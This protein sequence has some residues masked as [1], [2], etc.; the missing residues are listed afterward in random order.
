MNYSK[1]TLGELLSSPDDIIRRNAVS[2]LKRYQNPG[3]CKIHHDDFLEVHKLTGQ[4]SCRSC[5]I[6]KHVFNS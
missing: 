5:I 4:K 3:I 1:I 6:S 2:I